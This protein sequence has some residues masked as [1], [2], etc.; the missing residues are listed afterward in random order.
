MRNRL[1]DGEIFR[2]SRRLGQR[3]PERRSLADFAF[4]PHCPAVRFHQI[5][6]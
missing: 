4:H 2:P 3:E 6:A 1:T 5:M